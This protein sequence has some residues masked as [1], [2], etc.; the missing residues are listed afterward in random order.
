M[1]T[2]FVIKSSCRTL[3]VPSR[4]AASSNPARVSH[5]L[6][7]SLDDL[8]QLSSCKLSRKNNNSLETKPGCSMTANL[9]LLMSLAYVYDYIEEEERIG[10]LLP[11]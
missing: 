10:S 11:M 4:A 7:I 6:V 3:D 2:Q 1:P 5:F 9:Y 8:H